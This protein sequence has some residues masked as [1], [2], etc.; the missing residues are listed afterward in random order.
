MFDFLA[1]RK[2]FFYFVFKPVHHALDR[3]RANRL[4]DKGV[5]GACQRYAA[6]PDVELRSDRA[7]QE[8]SVPMAHPYAFGDYRSVF[9]QGF[10]APCK[11][12]FGAIGSHAHESRD[13]L[14]MKVHLLL[15]FFD[16]CIEK[17]I[18]P[19]IRH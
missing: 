4:G 2:G 9:E 18:I 3:G 11:F 6:V 13:F 7:A 14:K 12:S 19:Q 1:S 5:G 17:P 10:D 15:V 16:S 8:E